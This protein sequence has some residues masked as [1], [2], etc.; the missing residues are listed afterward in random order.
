MQMLILPQ[1]LAPK[2]SFREAMKAGLNINVNTFTK[3]SLCDDTFYNTPLPLFL[4]SHHYPNLSM[5]DLNITSTQYRQ[6]AHSS[7]S[8]LSHSSPH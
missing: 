8:L 3:D 2:K 1:E 6:T 7:P 5:H 4:S